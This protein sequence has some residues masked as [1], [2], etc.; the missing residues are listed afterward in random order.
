[1]G[2]R[3]GKGAAAC[4]HVGQHVLPVV[5][6]TVQAVLLAEFYERS[7][8]LLA[9]LRVGDHAGEPICPRIAAKAE[10]QFGAW[11][12]QH[13]VARKPRGSHDQQRLGDTGS[14]PSHAQ[15]E[16]QLARQLARHSSTCDARPRHHTC[17]T[18]GCPTWPLWGHGTCSIRAP[19]FV[20]WAVR[21]CNVQQRR[22]KIQNMY[23]VIRC[24]S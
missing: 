9:C 4:V 16:R 22:G 13:T 23:F 1:M 2:G 6:D 7:H 20:R 24:P 14:A 19:L 18:I 3:E 15:V 17:T 10:E 5:V 12:D 8:K 11:Q 21:H